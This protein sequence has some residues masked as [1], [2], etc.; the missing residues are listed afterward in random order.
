M[1]FEIIDLFVKPLYKSMQCYKFSEDELKYITN[2]N[3]KHNIGNQI[4]V[5]NNTNIFLE[6]EEMESIR[7]FIE[8]E[9][10]QYVDFILSPKNKELEFYIVESWATY[11]E[12]GHYHF[13][14]FHSNS[15]FSGCLYVNVDED[16]DKIMFHNDKC[17]RIYIAPQT[18]NMY[19]SELWWVPVKNGQLIMFD[20]SL[21]HSVPMTTSTKTRICLAFNV[22]VKGNL[23]K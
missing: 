3:K 15:L 19:N 1:E 17:E 4:S 14:H 5:D 10:S 13:S 8:R 9:I 2:F 21:A 22:L 23:C 6:S 11:A 20:S 7:K 16:C 18:Y 12:P